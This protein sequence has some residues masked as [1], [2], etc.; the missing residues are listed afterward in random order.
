MRT[1]ILFAKMGPRR[2]GLT[3][4]RHCQSGGTNQCRRGKSNSYCPPFPL[5]GEGKSDTF[6]LAI[7]TSNG[8]SL[9]FS[10]P[11][12]RITLLGQLLTEEF[13]SRPFGRIHVLWLVIGFQK[14]GVNYRKLDEVFLSWPQVVFILEAG[15]TA[16]PSGLISGSKSRALSPSLSCLI[17]LPSEAIK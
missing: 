6:R 7:R 4:Q 12:H 3:K 9:G 16:N 10:R 5:R 17:Y 1:T 15:V 11:F 2:P 8:F 14:V 13:F